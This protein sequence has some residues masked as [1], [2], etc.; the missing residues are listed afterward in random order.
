MFLN[1]NLL[2]IPLVI[3]TTG[4]LPMD[5]IKEYSDKAPVALVSNFSQGIPEMI[6]VIKNIDSSQWDVRLKEK[7]HVHKKDAP[8]GTAKTL[9]SVFDHE[10]PIDSVRKGEIFGEHIVTFENEDEQLVIK[11]TAKSRSLF[12]NGAVRYAILRR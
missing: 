5:L 10:I 6:N 2:T 9:A 12:A 11:H 8:S 1:Q 7:H 4:N 3:G